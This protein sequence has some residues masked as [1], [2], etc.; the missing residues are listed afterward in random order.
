M[1]VFKINIIASQ[2]VSS[3][4]RFFSV[5]AIVLVIEPDV[6]MIVVCWYCALFSV[7]STVS[8]NSYCAV[9]GSWVV[10][11]LHVFNCFGY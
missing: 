4:P 3:V 1:I 5:F 2:T 8:P 7:I 10:V 11:L 6:Y 9:F